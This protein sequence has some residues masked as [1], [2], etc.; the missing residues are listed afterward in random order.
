MVSLLQPFT[1]KLFKLKIPKVPR[2]DHNRDW[3][4]LFLNQVT[5]T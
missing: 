3:V 1:G 2:P 4:F 5:L